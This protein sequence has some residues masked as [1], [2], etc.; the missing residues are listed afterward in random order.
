[1]RAIVE[2]IVADNPEASVSEYPAMVKIDAPG[3]LTLRR[4]TVESLLRRPSAA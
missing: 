1:A 4:A 2:A 3:R